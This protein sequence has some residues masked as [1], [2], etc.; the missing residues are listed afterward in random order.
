MSS[1]SHETFAPVLFAGG[2]G[3][4]G[5][6]AVRTLRSLQPTL[7]IAIG[8]RNVEKARVLADEVGNA[9]AVQ[10]DLERADLGLEPAARYS[11]VVAL[12]KDEALSTMKYAQEHHVPWIS[13]ADFVFDVGPA[14]ARF[15]HQPSASP[16]LLLGQYL[17]GAASMAVLHFARRYRRLES[18]A[19]AG[20]LESDDT[21]G[22]AAQADFARLAHAPRPLLLRDGAFVWVSENERERVF[23]DGEGIERRGEAAPL[24]DVASLAAATDARSIRVDLAFREPRGGGRSNEMIIEL[25]GERLD[26]S[27]GRSRH[28]LVDRETYSALSGRGAAIAVERMLGLAGGAP[29]APGLHQLET[30][31]DPGYVMKRLEEL[32]TEI[33]TVAS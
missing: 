20:L 14:V 10:I 4:V 26:G 9:S 27:F 21:G 15:V 25:A 7:P 19:I 11:A 2:S 8:G 12:L 29:I 1:S 5:R 17:G 13:F 32:G 16:L 24:L 28:E 30:I 31:L 23:V 18:I 3:A 22:P 6:W 33:R